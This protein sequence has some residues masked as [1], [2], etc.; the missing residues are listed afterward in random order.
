MVEPGIARFHRFQDLAVVK[1]GDNAV[2]TQL[3]GNNLSGVK[4]PRR[5]TTSEGCA[6]RPPS[7]RLRER[8]RRVRA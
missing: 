3:P 2:L 5:R 4:T 8:D 1:V 7:A 6:L